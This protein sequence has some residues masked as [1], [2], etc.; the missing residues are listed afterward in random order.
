MDSQSKN[1]NRL[2]ALPAALAEAPLGRLPKRERTRRQLI[3][4][5]VGV[6]TRRGTA[7]AT[8][9]EIA[10]AAEVAP[11]TLY[12][13]FR[14]KDELLQGVALHVAETLCRRIAESYGHVRDA[15]ERMAIGNRRYIWLAEQSPGWAL[16]LLDIGLAVPHLAQQV[17]QDARADL[18]LGLKQK[19]FR[20]TSEAAAMD[21]I[22]GTVGQAMRSVALGLAPARH[23]VAVSAT[24]LRGLGMAADEALAV[25]RRPLPEFPV[26]G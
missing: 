11:A 12:N 9:Q 24:V 14:T 18:R 20:V 4:A 26:V 13:H 22:S 8:M 21:L 6:L 15:A 2:S 10:T 7:A 19:R 16:L 17:T 25:A 23:D 1:V 5:A 3:A